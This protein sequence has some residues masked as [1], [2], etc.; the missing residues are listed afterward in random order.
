VTF[1]YSRTAGFD[2]VVK[3]DVPIALND[4]Y[5]TMCPLCRNSFP[6][7]PLNFV[8]PNR[9]IHEPDSKGVNITVFPSNNTVIRTT[10]VPETGEVLLRETMPGG[11]CSNRE[12]GFRMWRH[13]N[14]SSLGY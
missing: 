14:G 9:K 5:G 3:P 4:S 13:E 11:V 1:A 12:E 8:D 10:V 2:P 6:I 7:L